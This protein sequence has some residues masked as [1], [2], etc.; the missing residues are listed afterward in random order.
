MMGRPGRE[1][2]F[3][4]VDAVI[5]DM[6]GVVTDTARI[7]ALAWKQAFDE[8]LRREARR[9]GRPFRAFDARR[10]Y[11]AYVDG[12]QRY[13][14]VRSFLSSRAIS[15]PDG[16]PD[17]PPDRETVCGLG[18]RKNLLFLSRLE[19][20]GVAAYPSTVRLAK[21]LRERGTRTAI[22][23]A[24]RNCGNVIRAAAVDQLF[25]VKVDGVDLDSMGLKGKPA[26]DIFLEAARLLGCAPSR[27]A[28][29]E[30]SLAGIEAARSGGVGLIIGV[31]RRGRGRRLKERG[32]DIVVR[33]LAEVLDGDD[34]YRTVERR[35]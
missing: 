17:D 12:K 16:N 2:L 34:Q 32:A 15:L 11:T 5:F 22:V 24:S 1:D 8:Y 30:D 20:S 33:D 10:D 9:K 26:P 27:V 7:H 19:R 21:R 31:D 13:D 35:E 18:N 23:S 25:D 28:V 6:D 4:G 29:I 3:V 14:G